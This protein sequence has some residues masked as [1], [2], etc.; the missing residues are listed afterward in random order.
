MDIKRVK[1]ENPMISIYNLQASFSSKNKIPKSPIYVDVEPTNA[2]NFKCNFC[3]RNQMKRKI[4]YMN[5]NQFKIV[6]KSAKNA[7]AKALRLIGW[8]EPFL[9][10]DIYE[11]IRVINSHNMVSHATTNGILIDS[12]KILDS[13]LRSIYFSMQGLNEKEYSVFQIIDNIP[14]KFYK[15]I[16]S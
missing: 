8:G 11:M 13:G 5:L 12:E 6:A 14:S 3:M 15:E 7:N 4:C 2:C 1:V 10:K 16:H 9:N